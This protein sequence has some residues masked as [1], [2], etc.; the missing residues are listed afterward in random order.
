MSCISRDPVFDADEVFDLQLPAPLHVKAG[1]H[2]TPIEVARHAAELLAPTTERVLDVGS[3][4][5][6]FCIPAAKARASAQFVGVEWRRHLVELAAHL[7]GD[8]PNVAFIHADA[9]ELD[10][11]A[12]DAFYFFNRFG[13]LV[14][15]RACWLDDTIAPDPGS[16]LLYISAAIQ[17]LRDARAGTRVVTYHG[18]GEPLPACYDLVRSD[19]FGTDRVELWIKTREVA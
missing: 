2:F 13:E 6:K 17:R 18:L 7:A 14:Q 1:L 3:G 12:F 5:G 11:S 19:S 9:F 10:W 8:V 4:V 16:Y 15:P